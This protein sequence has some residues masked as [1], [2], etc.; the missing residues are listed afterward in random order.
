[1]TEQ[2]EVQQKRNAAS[3]AGKPKAEFNDREFRQ[4]WIKLDWIKLDWEPRV[5]SDIAIARRWA[6]WGFEQ[7]VKAKA[8]EMDAFLAEREAEEKAFR[9]E[10][11]ERLVEISHACKKEYGHYAIFNE[12]DKV[13]AALGG[14]KK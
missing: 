2:P 1:M 11:A 14:E 7:G 3:V 6:R 10:Q 12:I 4:A 8:S 13:A 9:E 5:P